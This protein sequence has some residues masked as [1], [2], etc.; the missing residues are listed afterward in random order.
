LEHGTQILRD[1]VR[2]CG[3]ESP[4]L[5]EPAGSLNA[6]SDADAAQ[7]KAADQKQ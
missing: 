2:V 5:V 4:L 7:E 3:P 1:W 6:V